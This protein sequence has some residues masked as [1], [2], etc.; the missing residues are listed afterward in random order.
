MPS[1]ICPTLWLRLFS[2]Y[3]QW[4]Y[5]LGLINSFP[6]LPRWYVHQTG[7]ESDILCA[8]AFDEYCLDA[9]PRPT[10]GQYISQSKQLENFSNT[11]L[12]AVWFIVCLM[13]PSLYT[14]STM[15]NY[16]TLD[17]CYRTRKKV[18]LLHSLCKICKSL[19]GHNCSPFLHWWC[20]F[21]AW[22]YVVH[23]SRWEY[24]PSWFA[25]CTAVFWLKLKVGQ[26]PHLHTSSFGHGALSYSSCM[27]GYSCFHTSSTPCQSTQELSVVPCL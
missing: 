8:W 23:S 6:D 16:T 4:R 15:I 1:I 26:I 7:A 3:L 12:S 27:P 11:Y 2:L 10:S 25:N 20:C 9:S 24:A 5:T 17:H 22:A 21:R 14:K 13:V 19:L 18:E